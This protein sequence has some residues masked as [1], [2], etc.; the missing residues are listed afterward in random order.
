VQPI[1]FLSAPLA[2]GFALVHIFVGRLHFLD[3]KPRSRW[4][5]FSSGVAVAYVF[6]HLL[7]ELAAHGSAF[8]E[9]FG[10]P[11]IVSDSLVYA[12][13]LVGLTLFYAT[14]RALKLSGGEAGGET[15]PDDEVFWLHIG[16]SSILVFT[17]AYLLNYR[18]DTGMAGLATYFVAMALHFV[19]ADFGTRLD[20]PDLY[21]RA[22]RWVLVAATLA[23]WAAGL[24]IELS[25]AAIGFAFGF[26]SGAIILTVLKEELPAERESR[27]VPFVAG[28][29]IYGAL[30]FGELFLAA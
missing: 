16:L 7:P 4:L 20:H 8:R 3:E 12:L 27:L 13:A 11:P 24:L 17:I 5:S 1:Q 23:G 14:E 25:S 28:V 21:D 9:T 26:V 29:V 15:T 19:T 18:E 6:L 22:G 30:V 10:L 2:F